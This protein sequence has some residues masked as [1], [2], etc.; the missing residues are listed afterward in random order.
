[1]AA[2]LPPLY[3]AAAEAV[4]QL[5][6]VPATEFKVEQP[7]R[8]ELGDL[9]VGVFALAKLRKAP[10]PKIAAEIAAAFRPDVHGQGLLASATAAGP[11]VNFKADR[12]AVMRMLVEASIMRRLVPRDLGAGK[13][14]C[15]D[16]SSPN[17]SKALAFHHIR[18]TGIGLALVRIFR[19]LGWTV[20]GFNH[21]GDWGTTHGMLID[22]WKKWGEGDVATA[23]LDIAQL[24][25]LY[26]RWRKLA[27]I[28][29]DE[30]ADVWFQQLTGDDAAKRETALAEM[31]DAM[32]KAKA[33]AAAGPAWFARLEQGDDEARKIW[34]RFRD[35]SWAE[36]DA[37]YKRLGIEFEETRGEAAY[38]Q[39]LPGVMAELRAKQLV[40]E[41]EGAQVV[42]L[43]DEKIPVI[44]E[45][46]DGASTYA[47]RD[48][49]S[50][51]Y[52]YATYH[53]DRSLYVV[54]REQNLHFRQVF[55]LLERAG[56]AWAKQCEHVSFG[57][58][59]VGGKKS[60]TRAGGALLLNDVLR[61]AHVRALEK[62]TESTSAQ[63][64][65]A[66]A[67]PLAEQVGIAGVL[68]SNL[69]TQ[70]EKDIAFDWD[71]AL[72]TEGDSG[73]YL[74]Y[75]HARC[76]S[77]LRKANED[78]ATA[79]VDFALLATDLE[80][81]VARRLHDFG[82]VVARAGD[83]CEPHLV[84]HYLLDLAGDFSRWYT[85]GN[86]KDAAHLRVLCDDAPTRAA[87]LALT[88]AVQRTLAQGLHLLGI[89]APD[90]M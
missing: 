8:P 46:R 63:M 55:K 75:A 31:R 22:A 20:V 72:A 82:D 32:V 18:S 59:T 34:Q 40:H 6:D 41:S 12:A 35:V 3:R 81:A 28:G 16:Y 65:L 26:V 87:R 66:E 54:A 43:P 42:D 2:Y 64:P 19:A 70:R 9:A 56:Y 49:A 45:K 88:L 83:T 52:R 14:L 86:A 10:P 51:K 73:P 50:A 76:A 53:F 37:V 74:Q 57:L 33:H 39:D 36:F 60:S 21:L 77:I 23:D 48:F 17:V 78:V 11:Y 80:W 58:I 7:P 61:E 71:K 15:I 85:A 30:R 89:T 13:T 79:T 25:D 27:D 67:W 1:M 47:T 4:A 84:C 5:T 69:V 38:E 62:M 68:F 24:N 90:R 44:V 29:N